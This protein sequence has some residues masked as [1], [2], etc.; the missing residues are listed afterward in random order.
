MAKK[1]AIQAEMD[2]EI[3]A[4]SVNPL[5][6]AL[7][8]NDKHHL[9]KANI[10]TAFLKTGFP[11]FDYY[12][13]STMNIHDESGLIVTQEPRAGQAAGTF[14]LIVGN[15]GSGKA[16]PLSTWLPSP[17]G[18]T[19]M[20]DLVVG[21]KLF[22]SDGQV[23]QVTGIYPQGM[24]DVYKLLFNDGRCA[25]CTTDHLWTVYDAED[26]E[27]ILSLNE[28]LDD[29][30]NHDGICSY[31]FPT[32]QRPVQHP[33]RNTAVDPYVVG[34]LL[35]IFLQQNHYPH[36]QVDT[37]IVRTLSEICDVTEE[38]MHRTIDVMRHANGT[39][40]DFLHEKYGDPEF[41]ELIEDIRN[42][43][44]Q[45]DYEYNG[46]RERWA[47]L[48]GLLDVAGNVT[49]H[50][51]KYNESVRGYP[52]YSPSHFDIT[53]FV[54]SSLLREQL[55][56]ILR[57]MGILS[58]VLY[59]R[60]P[61]EEGDPYTA[62]IV[63][64]PNNK[65]IYRLFR[66][67]RNASIVTSI[68]GLDPE[69]ITSQRLRLVDVYYHHSE[70]CQCIK[71]DAED[72]LYLTEDFIVTHNTTLASQMAANIIMRYGGNVIH[73][74][75]ENRFDMSRC[76]IITK[77]PSRYFRSID[78]LPEPYMIRGGRVGLDVI[79]EMIAKI[80]FEKM[81]QKDKL[82]FNADY[83]DEFKQPI[84]VFQPTV[85]I[86]DSLATV[87]SETFNPESTKDASDAE[88]MRSNTDGAR[89]AKTLRGFLK[90]ILPL[91]KEANILI[92]GIN[93]IN[94]NMG[95]N[96]FLP[97]AKQQNFLK[98]DE[99]I[100]GG[101]SLIYSAQNIVKL[102][103]RTSDSFSED[104]DGFSG[105]IVMIEPVKSSSNQSGNNSKGISFE[106]VFS[107]KTGFDSLRSLILYGRDNGLILGNKP[108]LKFKDDD[109][110]TFNWKNLY[111]E[112]KEHPI[113]ENVFKY[114]VPTLEKH[115]SFIDPSERTFDPRSLMY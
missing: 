79:Q 52:V 88:K 72:E 102:V 37:D 6:A 67:G 27:V 84:R 14:N 30:T 115:L 57:S 45:Y 77:L 76:E 28:I 21:D 13:G 114:I 74:D 22:G 81:R 10:N 8:E 20:K 59:E 78:G 16:Q 86:I 97:V 2:R 108:K 5:L 11:Q 101:R 109:S 63:L 80:Y 94:Q 75:C 3:A 113:Y 100:P 73:F 111:T 105:Y 39:L 89:D 35:G 85:I 70:E 62:V 41:Y 29:V 33:S 15:T 106:L 18:M 82:M 48:Q 66:T 7:A 112:I 25:Y 53:L 92:Y 65:Q 42:Q 51:A 93:H 71:V 91:C 54:N 26:N 60:T 19:Q 96:S 40:Q 64:R 99:S 90:D 110:F 38:Q 68:I 17:S 24:Q 1:D 58:Y 12:F 104:T 36:Y 87:L 49:Y 83:Y 9:F 23:I 47:F 31:R 69:E 56:R 95:M 34:S 98:Q 32:L 55:L 46:E 61:F 103:A 50:L 44:I 107:Q 4:A 43:Y